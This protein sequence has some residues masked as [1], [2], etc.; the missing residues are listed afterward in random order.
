MGGTRPHLREGTRSPLSATGF[1]FLGETAGSR[2]SIGTMRS[3]SGTGREADSATARC[4]AARHDIAQDPVSR[5]KFL[6]ISSPK[7]GGPLT[8]LVAALEA[9]GAEI[10]EP[11]ARNNQIDRARTGWAWRIGQADHRDVRD[12]GQAACGDQRLSSGSRG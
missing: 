3:A 12:G 6:C 4:Y 2:T 8:A 5:E 11:F 10:W 1:E 9:M 7:R